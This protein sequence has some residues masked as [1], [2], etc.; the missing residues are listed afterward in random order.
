MST[1]RRMFEDPRNTYIIENSDPGAF[2]KRFVGRPGVHREQRCCEDFAPVWQE[3]AKGPESP[4][5]RDDYRANYVIQVQDITGEAEHVHGDDHIPGCVYVMGPKSGY[6]PPFISDVDWMNW[7]GVYWLAPSNHNPALPNPPRWVHIGGEKKFR[8]ANGQYEVLWCQECETWLEGAW[9]AILDAIP[10]VAR[11]LAMVASYIPVYGT[12]LSL[13]INTTVSLAEGENIDDALVEGIGRALPGQP[14]SGVIY[15]AGVSIAKG[16]RLSDTFLN[17]TASGLNLDK[18]V[19]DVLKAADEAIYNIASGQNIGDVAYGTIRQFLPDEAQQGMQLARRFIN[20]ENVPEMILSQSEQFLAEEVRNS[21]RIILEEARRRGPAELRE[22]EAR[23]NAMFNQYA[24][25]FGYQ[26]A[27]DRLPED[28]RGQIQL[29]MTAGAA[30]ARRPAQFI[31]TFGSVPEKNVAANDSYEAKG[32]GLIASGIKYHSK[33]VSDILQQDTFS[34]VV[35]AYDTLNSVW[36]RRPMVYQITDAWRRGFTIA[37]GVCEGMSVRDPGQLAVYQTLAEAGGR[38]GFDAGQAVQFNRTLFGDLGVD[39][40][41]MATAVKLD[42]S[43]TL[44]EG[45]DLTAMAAKVDHASM[46]KEGVDLTAAVQL[47]H[48]STVEALKK[49][50]TIEEKNS[51]AKKGESIAKSDKLIT[52]FRNLQQ[53]APRRL[54]FDI[55]M[56]VTKVGVTEGHTAWGPGKQR[57]LDSLS[58]D[59]QIGFKDAATFCLILNN[60]AILAVKGAVIANANPVV[61][62]ARAQVSSGLFWLGFDIATGIFGDPSLGAQGNTALGPGSEKIRSTIG[63]IE[64]I[65]LTSDFAVRGFNASVHLHLGPPPLPRRG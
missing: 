41:T 12:A 33:L 45:I 53:N 24:V 10:V 14:A 26:M 27:L 50:V 16:E 31:G 32:A 20:G 47:D 35:D 38:A 46:L 39:L 9:S 61:A 8:F 44:K 17:A 36:T 49:S 30:Y 28:V 62:A 43:S 48:S 34:I 40:A 29:G 59:E 65:L 54:G 60:N 15:T 51:F 22:A 56:G 63:D 58:A 5:S 3:A 18:S 25:E 1:S 13:V 19:T 6:K 64:H 37:I 2:D 55:G 11:A 57:T 23:V 7:Q 4:L 21:A 52:E 42:Y